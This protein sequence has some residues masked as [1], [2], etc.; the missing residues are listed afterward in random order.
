MKKNIFLSIKCFFFDDFFSWVLSLGL[1]ISS[2]PLLKTLANMVILGL[3]KILKPTVEHVRRKESTSL[4]EAF[5]EGL[6]NCIC[7]S[8]QAS[9]G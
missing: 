7:F 2:A 4:R 1:E 5:M 8:V 9:A 6:C 3:S